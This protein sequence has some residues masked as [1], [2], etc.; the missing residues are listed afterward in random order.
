MINGLAWTSVGGEVLT[1]EV[2]TMKGTGK[3]SLTGKLGDVMKESAQAA[4]SYIRSNANDLGIYSKVFSDLDIHVHVPEGGTPKDGPSAGIA[5]TSAIVSALTGIPVRKDMAMTGEITLRGKILPI[6][7]LK[8]KLLAAKRNHLVEVLIPIEN[9]KDL[10]DI[11]E[12]I[13]KDLKIV[14]LTHVKEVLEIVL[15][16]QPKPVSDEEL[17]ELES[18]KLHPVVGFSTEDST[19]KPS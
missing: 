4:I 12:E 3:T 2:S 11:D 7:G 8:E 5:I 6:G 10:A 13:K 17:E 15:V 18:K 9:K 14:P 16:S 1:I 19:V